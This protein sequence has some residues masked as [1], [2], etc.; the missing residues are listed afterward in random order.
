MRPSGSFNPQ[1]FL[2]TL[3]SAAFAL[4]LL[5]LI[6]SGA[7]LNYVTPRLKPYLYFAAAIML[8]WAIGGALRLRLPR[9]RPRGAHCLVLA[10]PLLLFLL[11]HAPLTSA[12]L[13]WSY[14]PG[15][16]AA[17]LPSSAVPAPA[18]A[19]DAVSGSAD[20]SAAADSTAAPPGADATDKTIV[21]ADDY[22]YPWLNELYANMD[23]YEGWRIYLTGFV[24]KD[25]EVFQA[26]EFMTSRL[27]MSCC[28]AD[29]V[30]YG[31]ICRSDGA[32]ALEANSW[33]TI[34]G[35]I[36][37]TE[38]DGWPEPQITVTGVAAAQEIPG[39][40]YPFG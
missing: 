19:L 12:D 17:A 14:V 21:V 23:M 26:D 35:V 38:Y 16:S 6:R 5:Y 29:L 1:I 28:V 22:F 20:F 7:Y 13:S 3:C 30:P 24:F 39:Y 25:P 40:I 37:A 32:A 31:L 36:H 15:A 34:E 9:R 2:E 11:P 27:G 4:L 18:L 10:A 8:I 33:I